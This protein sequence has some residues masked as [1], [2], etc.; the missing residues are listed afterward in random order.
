[1][2]KLLKYETTLLLKSK[3][4][5]VI[6]SIAVSMLLLFVWYWYNLEKFTDEALIYNKFAYIDY[7]QMEID[8]CLED[9]KF[10]KRII[11]KYQNGELQGFDDKQELFD[12]YEQYEINK[13][14][15]ENGMSANDKRMQ[16]ISS[17]IREKV[18]CM[19]ADQV[20]EKKVAKIDDKIDEH[21]NSFYDEYFEN[22]ELLSVFLHTEEGEIVD[23]Y[24]YG[25][26]KEF[27][28]LNKK[29]KDL[30]VNNEI[31]FDDAPWNW[32][33]AL[34]LK[35][36]KEDMRLIIDKVDQK[37]SDKEEAT[38]IE[39]INRNEQI[40][41]NNYQPAARG[42]RLD[43]VNV[44]CTLSFL[45]LFII[46]VLIIM[47]GAS[48]FK[49]KT[50]FY[51]LTNAKKRY[52]VI[53]S[54]VLSAFSV[55]FAGIIVFYLL[56]M[57]VATCEF[58]VTVVEYELVDIFGK[59]FAFDYIGYA[60]Y[61]LVIMGILLFMICALS[62]SVIIII[63]NGEITSAVFTVVLMLFLLFLSLH[64]MILFLGIIALVSYCISCV[65]LEKYQG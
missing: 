13:I 49:N 34:V 25:I 51:K 61:R 17:Y 42:G 55:Y 32:K 12:I 20:D 10:N 24:E 45:F 52:Q 18:Q 19:I 8:K 36:V 26:E 29:Y 28:G 63:K 37:I 39:S 23:V 4:L 41:N 9:M 48:E 30:C 58:K 62:S 1:M 7:R 43:F 50:L 14:C 56:I 57:I 33:Y 60:M 64:Q 53:I 65:A 11:E 46:S 2:I 6:L 22:Q 35:M 5:T 3:R 54:Q 31:I 15:V 21:L 47:S 16:Y 38:I 44:A 27:N 59:L 40:L